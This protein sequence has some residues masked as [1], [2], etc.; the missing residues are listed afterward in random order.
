MT[1][2]TDAFMVYVTVSVLPSASTVADSE[3]LLFTVTFSFLIDESKEYP[4]LLSRTIVAVYS[5]PSS[6]FV[7]AELAPF[8]VQLTDFTV[9]FAEVSGVTADVEVD[10]VVFAAGRFIV[11]LTV[12]IFEVI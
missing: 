12:V 6:N 1:G 2:F 3:L 8:S 10:G 11:N 9:Y 4:E 7:A 5:F